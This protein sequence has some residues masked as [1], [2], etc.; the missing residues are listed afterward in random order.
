MHIPDIDRYADVVRCLPTEGTFA[1]IEPDKRLLL[2][3][4]RHAATRL[5]V[6]WAPF[7]YMNAAARICIVGITP[8]RNQAQDASVELYHQ[9][10]KGASCRI[11]LPRSQADG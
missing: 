8:G 7:D 1:A 3:D 4:G 6:Y 2:G 9:L 5:R 10:T 11:G